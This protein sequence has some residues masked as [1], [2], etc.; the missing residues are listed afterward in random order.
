LNGDDV[1]GVIWILDG[2]VPTADV[3]RDIRWAIFSGTVERFALTCNAQGL[4]E[5]RVGK[6][7]NVHSL[8]GRRS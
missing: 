4:K 8:W 3:I 5:S 6:C 2:G 1:D 7:T